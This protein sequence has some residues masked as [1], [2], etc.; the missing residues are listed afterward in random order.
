MGRNSCNPMWIFETCRS[1]NIRIF[2][3]STDCDPKYLRAM[4]LI[5][6]FFAKLPNI[7]IIERTDVFEVNLP[8]TWSSWF[9]YAHTST[10]F[11]FSRSCAFMHKFRNRLLSSSASMIIGEGKI[12][13]DFLFDLINS[14]SKLIHGLV[15]TDAQPKDKQ[16]FPSCVKISNDDVLPSLEDISGSYAT[17]VYLRLVRSIILAYIEGNT[18]TMDRIYHSCLAVFVCRLWWTWL[19][20]V[21]MKQISTEHN[22][23]DKSILKLLI[24]LLK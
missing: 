19:Q 1:S 5:T 2:S 4:R 6:G 14:Q 3:F 17:R 24:V 7:P 11:L 16:N 10:I 13:M 21:T 18:P 20:L 15:K 12:S 8:R 23:K 22:D 9:F